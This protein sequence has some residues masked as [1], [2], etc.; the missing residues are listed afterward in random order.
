MNTSPDE[1]KSAGGQSVYSKFTIDVAPAS[2]IIYFERQ[3][4][5]L[6]TVG[7]VGLVED[8][9]IHTILHGTEISFCENCRDRVEMTFLQTTA[10]EGKDVF[11][12]TT[13]SEQSDLPIHAKLS[14]HSWERYIHSQL[15]E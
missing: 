2:K 15:S 12:N 5:Q 4:N 8:V 6:N 7:R 13:V 11:T 10:N 3:V 9:V 14:K 1:S